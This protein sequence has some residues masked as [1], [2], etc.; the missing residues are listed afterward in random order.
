M[1]PFGGREARISTAPIA[2]GMPQEDG[3]HFILDFATSRVAEGKVLVS[4]K[5]GTA[6]PADAMVDASGKDSDQPIT[7]YGKTATSAVP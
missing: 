5:T 2:I 1:L 3:K 6:L 4:Q 7:I